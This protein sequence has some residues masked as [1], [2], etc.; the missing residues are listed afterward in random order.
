MGRYAPEY[1][2]EL[3][4]GRTMKLLTTGLAVGGDVTGLAIGGDVQPPR[5]I[6]I[7]A[8]PAFALRLITF[9]VMTRS[10][11]VPAQFAKV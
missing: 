9:A 7:S 6:E 4:L 3:P 5:Q 11:P 8:I 2:L 1:L 10:C